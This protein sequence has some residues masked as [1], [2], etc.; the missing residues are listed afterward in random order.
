MDFKKQRESMVKHQLLSRGITDERLLDAFRM[1]ERHL[2]VPLSMRSYAYYDEPLPI[3]KGQTISQPYIIALMIDLLE[4]QPNDIVLEIGTGS[5]YQTALLANLAKKIYSIERISELA[6][7]AEERLRN[8]G[9]KNIV[10]ATGDG[11][12]G[13]PENMEE[14]S[15]KKFDAIIV[16]A[17]APRVLP[18][19]LD[20]LAEGG[21][22]VIP[23]GSQFSQDIWRVSKEK[24]KIK[25]ENYGGCIFV[26]LIGKDGWEK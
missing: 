8:L 4:L 10:I 6:K 9:Y 20:Q 19:L 15:P 24:G 21:R 25:K 22:M 5:G 7:D 26:P 12:Q 14:P 16:S 2:F 11:T 3:G 23:I 1:V 17:A 18:K 13:W